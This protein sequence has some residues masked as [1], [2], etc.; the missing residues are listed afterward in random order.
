MMN[1]DVGSHPAAS[2]ASQGGQAGR[3]RRNERIGWGLMQATEEISDGMWL[4][5]GLTPTSLGMSVLEERYQNLAKQRDKV[6][7]P[8]QATSSQTPK[9]PPGSLRYN[10]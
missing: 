2:G 6:V 5:L 4:H 3:K 7:I 9:T 1:L 10:W 8:I